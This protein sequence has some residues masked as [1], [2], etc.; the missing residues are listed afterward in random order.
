MAASGN[1]ATD[2][3]VRAPA[4]DYTLLLITSVKISTTLFEK[5]NFDF[6]RD[7]ALTLGG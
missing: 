1:I 5:L 6:I 7:I 4:D 2:A 3:V